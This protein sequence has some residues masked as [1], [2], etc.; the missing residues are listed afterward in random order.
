MRRIKGR[1]FGRIKGRVFGRESW[2]EKFFTP[3]IC[4]AYPLSSGFQKERISRPL[5][6]QSSG[7]SISAKLPLYVSAT[8]GSFCRQRI[9]VGAKVYPSLFLCRKPDSDLPRIVRSD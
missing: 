5:R 6:K 9:F 4:I 3:N 2:E 1:M 8:A 7:C